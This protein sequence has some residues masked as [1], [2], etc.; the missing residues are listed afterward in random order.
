M[1]RAHLAVRAR[2]RAAA[3]AQLH[4]IHRRTLLPYP[5]PPQ[6]GM[7]ELLHGVVEATAM[8]ARSWDRVNKA[9]RRQRSATGRLSGAVDRQRPTAGHHNTATEPHWADG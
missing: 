3:A 4:C 1:A 8:V 6:R 7:G 9:R 2:L 5:T